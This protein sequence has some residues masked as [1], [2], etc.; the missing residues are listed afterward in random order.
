MF[1]VFCIEYLPSMSC[2]RVEN[3]SRS[4]PN[5]VLRDKSSKLRMF[6]ILHLSVKRQELSTY[7][8]PQQYKRLCSRP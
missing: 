5:T 4:L 7:I 6:L 3:I 2:Y 1:D 8:S